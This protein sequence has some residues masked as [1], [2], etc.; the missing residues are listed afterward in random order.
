MAAGGNRGRAGVRGR[1]HRGG[2]VVCVSDQRPRRA[3]RGDRCRGRRLPTASAATPIPET[4]TFA[5][6]QE[7]VDRI[8]TVTEDDLTAAIAG[9]VE[10]E[11]LVAEGA[12]AA[13]IAALVGRPGRGSRPARRGDRERQQHRPRAARRRLL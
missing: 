9:L 10:H 11:H 4:I 3:A 8:E 12:G 5:L 7:L 2:G 13:A 6:I 1:R